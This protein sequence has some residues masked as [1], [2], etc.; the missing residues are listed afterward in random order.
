MNIIDNPR[1]LL[2]AFNTLAMAV[3]VN[4]NLG[5]QYA[6]VHCKCV[7]LIHKFEICVQIYVMHNLCA[8]LFAYDIFMLVTLDAF[9][10]IY[11]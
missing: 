10:S 6:Q 9:I 5:M 1:V 11:I 3:C 7:G 4:L 2:L 8:P